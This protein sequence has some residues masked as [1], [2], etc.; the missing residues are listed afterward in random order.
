MLRH[1]F[2]YTLKPY[3]PW[4][5]R[6]GVRRVFARRKRKA[7]EHTWPIDESAATAPAGWPGWPDGKK[8]AFVLTHD[9]EGPE[10][11]AKCRQLAELEM[12]LGF[13]SCFN[14]IPE[15][16]YRVPPELRAWLIENGFEVGVHDLQHDGHL[17]D[18]RDDFGAKAAR[19]NHYAHEWGAAGFR[20][21]FMLR[22]LDWLHALDVHYDSS[23]FDTDPFEPQP[24]AAGTIFPH[25]I[26]APERKARGQYEPETDRL[27]P[28]SVP[29]SLSPFVASTAAFRGGYVELPYTLPQDST[30]FLL[31]RERTSAIWLRKLDWVAA[32]GGMALVNV[33]P[34]YCRFEGEAAHR[35]TYP[36]ALY[37]ELLEHIRRRHAGDYWHALPGKLTTTVAGSLCQNALRSRHTASLRGKRAAVLLY[38]Y[39]PSDPRPRRAAEAMAEAGME[40]DL[41]CLSESKSDSRQETIRGVRVYRVP[42]TRMRGSMWAYFWQYGRF[43]LASVWFL[44]RQGLHRKY[45][46]VHV[47]NMPDF[48]AFATLPAKLRGSRVVLDLH[49]PMPELMMSIYGLRADRWQVRL[50]RA[51]ERWSIRAADLVLTPNLAFKNLF[52]ARSCPAYKIQIVMNSPQEDIFDPEKPVLHRA[53]QNGEFRLMHHGLIAHRHGIDLLVEA[54]ARVRPRIPGVQLDIYGGRTPFLDTVLE[55]AQKLNVADLVHYHGPKSQAEIAAAIQE[56]DLGVVPNRRSS[57]TE[58]NFPTRIFEYLAM[59]RPVLTP[60]TRGITDYFDGEQLLMFEPDNLADL[61]AKILLVHDDPAQVPVWVEHGRVIYRQHLWR[62]GKTH[63]LDHIANTIGQNSIGSTP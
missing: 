25:W 40:V 10:G 26:S 17:Y 45:D 36:V 62:E 14:F 20:S 19:I 56:C 6:M 43:F 30:L 27:D 49:D 42:M 3:L 54:V 29:T 55:V 34:D 9:V 31:L 12:E 44:L 32:H 46:V 24:D 18:A 7:C 8:F 35:R 39:Y 15:G 37:R 60:A 5:L 4:G 33:H 1:R 52:A 53:R 16:P 22:N 57:F 28:Y 41:L 63:F 11:L 47:H 59:S 23:T 38:S 58:L 51:L 2:Y 13:R 50:L 21:G 48:L 61:A